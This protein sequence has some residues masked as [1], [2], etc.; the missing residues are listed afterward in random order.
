M[1]GYDISFECKWKGFVDPN[2]KPA[3]NENESNDDEKDKK[4]EK[5]ATGILKMDEITSEDDPDDWE[6]EASIKKKS[7]VNKAGLSLVKKDRDS[8]I[9]VINVFIAEFK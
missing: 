4:K 3:D 2:Y 6:Y 7:K 1:G 9:E 5:K 8:V